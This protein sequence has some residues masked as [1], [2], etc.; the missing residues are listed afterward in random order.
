[1]RS[2]VAQQPGVAQQGGAEAVA[3]QVLPSRCGPASVVSRCGLAGGALQVWSAV[4]AEQVWPSMCGPA[5][6]AQ[7]VLPSRFR[8]AGVA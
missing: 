8:P 7:Q 3:Q 5:R 2:R 4:V 1:M 6:V